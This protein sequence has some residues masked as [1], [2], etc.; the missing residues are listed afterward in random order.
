M[1]NI[2]TLQI[3]IN[4]SAI[5]TSELTAKGTLHNTQQT[6]AVFLHK[7]LKLDGWKPTHF[8]ESDTHSWH[9]TQIEEIWKEIAQ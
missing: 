7:K 5:R 6:R 3:I 4:T 1:I 9:F 8:A 2:I